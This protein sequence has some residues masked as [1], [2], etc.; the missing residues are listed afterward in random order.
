MK[1]R[2]LIARLNVLEEE[3]RRRGNKAIRSSK[4]FITL[5]PNTYVNPSAGVTEDFIKEAIKQIILYLANNLEKVIDLNNPDHDWSTDYIVSVKIKYAI[6]Q[7]EGRMRKDGSF[8][9]NGGFIHAH[10]RIEIMHKSNISLSY[11]KLRALLQPEFM[12][13]FGKNGWI[14]TPR[15]IGEDQS[16]RYML[17]SKYYKKG[18]KW[19]TLNPTE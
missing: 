6:E 7:G 3:D 18:Y 8:P 15:L 10:V 17:K 5:N 14:S 1:K 2:D 16:E 9:S 12:E 11:S 19:V 4:W 13:L